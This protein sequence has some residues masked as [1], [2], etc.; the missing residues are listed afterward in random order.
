LRS[1]TLWPLRSRS[2]SDVPGQSRPA[3]PIRSGRDRA[4]IGLPPFMQI[5]E[6][7]EGRWLCKPS[8]EKQPHTSPRKAADCSANIRPKPPPALDRDRR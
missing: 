3:L 1:T 2:T 8:M 4:T 5:G 7:L 6:Q